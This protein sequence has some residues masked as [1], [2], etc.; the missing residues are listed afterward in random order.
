MYGYWYS[1][2][3]NYSFTRKEL[4]EVFWT[5]I[6]FAFMLT[7]YYKD[8]FV[9]NND[10]RFMISSEAFFFFILATG[11]VFL[12]MY[13]HVALQKLVGIKLGYK[14]NY[15]YWRN[16]ILIGLFLS[17]ISLG[18]VPILSLL[19]LP[20]SI[21][22]EHLPKLRMGKF[23]YGTNTKDIARISLAGPLSHIIIVMILGILYFMSGKDKTVFIF[24]TANLLLMIYTML[25]IPK[26]D[27]PSSMGSATDG[28][29]I[30]YHSRGLYV[31]GA[32]TVLFYAVLI[33]SANIFS[34]MLA[35]GMGIIATTIFSIATGQKN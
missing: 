21:T 12:C 25:P 33:W 22:L 17:V 34:F 1:V 30:F 5:S 9:I 3:E 10:I 27:L 18:K 14:V 2:R 6:A 8:I 15:Q 7:S 23:R 11:V 32:A 13:G 29:G 16:A 28:F 35:F 19:L 31:L 24:I 26:I 20:G 4:T